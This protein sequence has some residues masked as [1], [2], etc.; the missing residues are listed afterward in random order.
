MIV[1]DGCFGFVVIWLVV[2]DEVGLVVSRVRR[3][4]F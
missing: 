3:F 1:C 2:D 4:V